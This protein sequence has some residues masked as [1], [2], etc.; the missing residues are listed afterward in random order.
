[1]EHH[2][3]VEGQ[4]RIFH[5]TYVR[6]LCLYLRHRGVRLADALAGTGMTWRQLLHEK[7]L[8][9]FEAMR[10][11]VINA[12]R[13]TGCPALG[14]EW[15]ASVEVAAH[16]LS[17][18]AVAASQDVSEALQASVRYYPLR[19]RAVALDLVRDA[20]GATLVIREPIAFGDIRSFLLEALAAI[21]ERS[22]ATVAGGPLVGIVHRFPYTPPPWAPDY[23]RWLGGTISFRGERMEVR[24]P[25]SI[26]ALPGVLAEGTQAAAVI[27]AER[28]LA[29]QQSGGEW[30]ARI[31]QRLLEREGTYPGVQAMARDLN[32]STRTLLRKLRKEGATYQMLLDD[33]RKEVAE[34]YLVRTRE[35]IEAIADRLGYA[36]ASNFSRSFRRWFG[37]P[38][39]KFR[40]DRQ[41]ASI[42]SQRVSSG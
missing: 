19:G 3:P 35:P 17:G 37:T 22:M 21:V 15:G 18:A 24:L 34:W 32:M 30:V 4:T 7:R 33:A 25:K 8:I 10:S 1:M 16:G 13:L 38:P 6:L 41:N 29:L 14:L 26:L 20:D 36:D 2:I 28:Q 40:R 12:K 9:P 39:A 27:T 11:L 5:P 23:S 31:K 42:G